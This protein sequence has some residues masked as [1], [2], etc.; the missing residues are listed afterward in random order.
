VPIISRAPRL[1]QGTALA[2]PKMAYNPPALAAE[3][4]AAADWPEGNL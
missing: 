2:V 1:R 3:G 4:M